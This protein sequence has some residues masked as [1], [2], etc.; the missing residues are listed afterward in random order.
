[1]LGIERDGEFPGDSPCPYLGVRKPIKDSKYQNEYEDITCK[2]HRPEEKDCETAYEMYGSASE[3]PPQQCEEIKYQEL[4]KFQANKKAGNHKLECDWSTCFP[5]KPYIGEMNS[6]YG[7]VV[8]WIYAPS[9]GKIEEMI[10]RSMTNGFNFV[11][12]KCGSLRQVLS[13]PRTIQLSSK[14]NKVR[15]INVNLILIDS[16]S[17]PHFY[18]SMPQTIDALRHVVYNQ[19]IPATVLDFEL[20]QSVSQHTMDNCRP[21]YSGVTSGEYIVHPS[22]SVFI[23]LYPKQTIITFCYRQVFTVNSVVNGGNQ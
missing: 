4:C 12:F 21:L 23:Q 20:L 18:R 2:P 7:R 1:M 22:L 14:R 9:D 8:N 6:T 15:K 19:S 5:R 10:Y 13:L 17:R 11:F 16:I 3:H